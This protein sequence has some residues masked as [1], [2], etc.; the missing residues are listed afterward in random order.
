MGKPEREA[1]FA[2]PAAYQEAPPPSY[3]AT[4]GSSSGMPPPPQPQPQ[5]QQY[6]APRFGPVPGPAPKTR[7]FPPAFNVYKTGFLSKTYV[8]G[9]HQN[10]PLYA[11]TNHAWSGPDVTL[12][13]GP[14][15]DAPPLAS[16]S[17]GWLSKS[18]DIMLPPLPGRDASNAVEKVESGGSLSRTW[19]F[20]IESDAVGGRRERFE[21]R[22]SRGDKV[23]ALGGHS[24]GYKLVRLDGPP[25]A[26]PSADTSDG[27]EI[28]AV[29]T[30][31]GYSAS[32]LMTFQFLNSGNT[33]VL[34]E[35]WALMAV[36][37]ALLGH[38]VMRKRRS[39][40]AAG[41]GA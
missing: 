32:K 11:I 9:E 28:V 12:H 23:K 2:Q 34:G 37:T 4:A 19:E 38:D 33:G 35:R 26:G 27:K 36:I 8:L 31:A 6:A 7:T 41:G 30:P 24:Q 22:P 16:V 18:A 40:A 13:T 1:A 39:S 3:H 14:D 10:Q 20:A 21:W 17:E 15:K 25:G 5:P 29:W